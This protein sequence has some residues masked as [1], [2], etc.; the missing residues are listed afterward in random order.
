MSNT[1][2]HVRQQAG[3]TVES[4]EVRDFKALE[5][6]ETPLKGLTVLAGA[7]SSGKSSLLQ[8]L[9][10]VAQSNDQEVT[11]NGNLVRLGVPRDVIRNGSNLVSLACTATTGGDDR[12][13]TWNIELALRQKPEGLRVAECYVTRNGEPMLAASDSRVTERTHSSVDPDRLY[14]DTILRVREIDG[15]V[16]PA[17]TYLT[18]N[19]LQPVALHP[20][21]DERSMLR[22]LR[23]S[24]SLD[25]FPDDA[26]AAETF[27][28]IVFGHFY[29]AQNADTS[30]EL[31]EATRAVVSGGLIMEQPR[32][33]TVTRAMM[34]LL[35]R[36][37]AKKNADGGWQPIP[38]SPIIPSAVR[39]SSSRHL[40]LTIPSFESA[41]RAASTASAVFA[42]VGRSVRHLGPLRE[43]PQVVSKTATRSRTSPVGPRGELTADLLSTRTSKVSFRDWKNIRHRMTLT[44]AVSFWSEYLGI[45]N[46]VSVEDQGKLGRGIRIR[47]N[48]V[49]RDLTMIGVGASQLVPII[50][51]VLDAPPGSIV[52]LEQP[53]LHLHPSV[54]S[55]LGD[56]LLYAR[57]DLTI[58]AETHSEY[59]ITRLRR[60]VAEDR[61][62]GRTLHL[63][64]AEPSESGTEIREIG[65]TSFGNLAEWPE[66]F[67]D[68]QDSD[69]RAIV[70]ALSSRDIS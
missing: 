22:E 38:V 58:I 23:R 29:R 6:A 31:S 18:L 40:S 28:E 14:G 11:L 10:L 13:D 57:P 45:G 36:A 25:A 54:Q 46:D 68:S 21:V 50:A 62:F 49:A 19:G 70:H 56:F 1:Q 37:L 2:A 24:F 26:D 51:T 41:F 33:I 8:S 44:A 9:E 63:L 15:T 30:D 27:T 48:G 43:E 42:T 47:V 17:H 59:L 66:G 16:A 64:F 5:F 35:L 52:L 20:R 3:V 53:E 39:R 32:G 67:F 69:A 12:V 7:N 61:L 60:R 65:V 34:D 4:W 55:Q